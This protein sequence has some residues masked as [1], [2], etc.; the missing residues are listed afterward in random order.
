MMTVKEQQIG[1]ELLLR[2]FHFG[3]ITLE[4]LHIQLLD[5]NPWNEDTANWEYEGWNNWINGNV[6]M[7]I[8]GSEYVFSITSPG[9][10]IYVFDIV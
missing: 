9:S 2:K 4:H 8:D 3:D 6:Q 10:I 7:W 1:V 5:M